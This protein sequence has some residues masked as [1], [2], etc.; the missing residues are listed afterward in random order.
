MHSHRH[1]ANFFAEW[2]VGNVCVCLCAC[3]VYVLVLYKENLLT[4]KGMN[5]E[6][7]FEVDDK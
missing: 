2:M 4:W 6:Q 3:C 1:L 5:V 7:W